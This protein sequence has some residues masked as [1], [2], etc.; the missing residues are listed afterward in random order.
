MDKSKQVAPS[1]EDSFQEGEESFSG[2]GWDSLLFDYSKDTWK[3]GPAWSAGTL[4]VREVKVQRKD[5]Q[6]GLHCSI[7]QPRALQMPP[8]PPLSLGSSRLFEFLILSCVP[9]VSVMALE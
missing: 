8:L 9:L 6:M 1:M 5:M 2:F 7:G 3:L 4:E